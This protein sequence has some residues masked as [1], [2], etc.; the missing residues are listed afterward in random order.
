MSKL[1]DEIRVYCNKLVDRTTVAYI[2][3][4]EKETAERVAHDILE[5]ISK[6]EKD[7]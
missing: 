6:H 5:I 1:I 2:S 4:F 7:E 3:E